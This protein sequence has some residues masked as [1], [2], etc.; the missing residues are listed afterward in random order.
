M[1]ICLEKFVSKK[2]GKNFLEKLQKRKI[3]FVFLLIDKLDL[4]KIETFWVI[5]I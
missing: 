4:I 2:F 1:E 3:M 5:K